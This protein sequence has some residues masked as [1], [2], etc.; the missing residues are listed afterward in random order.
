[1]ECHVSK[2]RSTPVKTGFLAEMEKRSLI[3]L[4]SRRSVGST[5]TLATTIQP[6]MRKGL[7]PDR[8]T[9]LPANGDRFEVK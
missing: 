3:G 9:L 2:E 1:M 7:C 4:I 6:V 5:P 8:R